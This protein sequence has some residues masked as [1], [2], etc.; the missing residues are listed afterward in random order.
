MTLLVQP[1]QSAAPL[2]PR[3]RP[4]DNTPVS[5]LLAA[6]QSGIDEAPPAGAEPAN[7]PIRKDAYRET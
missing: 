7:E 3:E 2:G 5:H 1:L 4:A 6:I